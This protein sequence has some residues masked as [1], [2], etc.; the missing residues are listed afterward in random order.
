MPLV[1]LP[2]RSK[3]V[4]RDGYDRPMIVPKKGGKAVPHTR[5]TTFIDCVEDKSNLT[6]WGKRSVL[7]GAAEKPTLLDAVRDL[8]PEA[9]GYKRKLSGLAEAAMEASGANDKRE[10]GSYLHELS[11][12][13]DAGQPL[14]DGVSEADLDDMAAYKMATIDFDVKHTEQ[15]VVVNALKTAG[16]PDRVSYYTGPGPLP[17]MVFD[18]ELLITDLK[19]GSV[20][21]GSLKMAAQLAV[22]SR[23]EFY[24]HTVFPEVDTS[25]KKAFA[26]WKKLVHEQELAQRAYSPIGPVNQEWGV[27]FHLAAGSGVC[28]LHWVNL[29]IG[30]RLARLA[31]TIRAARATRGAMVPFRS[32]PETVGQV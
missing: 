12:L 21:Y 4:P 20:D 1:T 31:Q 15:L 29:T 6:D 8:D 10:R 14:P 2:P 25:D 18:N 32:S 23:G 19:T 16:T 22:Y 7:L 24:D 26:A 17:G 11:E 30:W 28:N 27:I 5:T 3:G 13:V 9:D